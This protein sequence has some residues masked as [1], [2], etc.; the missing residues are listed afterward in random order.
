MTNQKQYSSM[1]SHLL[2]INPNTSD[3]VSRLLK[4]KI[5]K[6]VPVGVEVD[7]ITARLGAPYIACEASYAVAG[8]AVLDAWADWQGRYPNKAKAVLIGCFGDPGLFALRQVCA[9]PV[10]GLAEAAF[11][12]AVGEAKR[13]RFAVVT[14][15]AGWRPMLERL[16]GALGYAT[17]LVGIETVTPSGAELAADRVMARRVIAEACHHATQKWSVEAVI[18][19]GAGLAGLA[20]EIQHEFNIPLVDSVM[21]GAYHTL[22]APLGKGAICGF[23]WK[24]VAREMDILSQTSYSHVS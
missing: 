3:S 23:S 10:M 9:V 12:S 4:D 14:G 13:R 6:V 2:V 22:G 16:A 18:V 7:V 24:G 19:G 11:I 17:E 15:G 1:D 5:E 20:E 21:A 8:H